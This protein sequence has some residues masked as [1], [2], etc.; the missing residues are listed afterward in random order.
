MVCLYLRRINGIDFVYC[1]KA[2]KKA[3]EINRVCKLCCLRCIDSTVLSPQSGVVHFSSE[4]YSV[5][6]HVCCCKSLYNIL[7]TCLFLCGSRIDIKNNIRISSRALSL[8]LSLLNC[9]P[10]A[11]ALIENMPSAKLPTENSP[12]RTV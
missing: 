1:Q 11:A 8:S 5:A 3:K 2:A 7:L 9:T 10:S 4:L 12:L 6:D